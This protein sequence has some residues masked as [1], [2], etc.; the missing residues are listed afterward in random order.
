VVSSIQESNPLTDWTAH[1]SLSPSHV[2][3]LAFST[4]SEQFPCL[5]QLTLLCFCFFQV[6]A[7]ARRAPRNR[8]HQVATPLATA[9][10][11]PHGHIARL[12]AARATSLP[13]SQPHTPRPRM[14]RNCTAT[15]LSTSQPHMSPHA[16]QLHG[17]RRCLPRSRT[18]RVPAHLAACITSPSPSQP[19]TPRPC[20]PR[21]CTGHV[22]ARLAAAHTTSPPPSQPHTQRHRAPRCCTGHVGAFLAADAASP[23]T[24]LL[25]GP[26]RRLPRSRCN[27]AAH[28][29]AA[30]ATSAPSPQPTQRRRAPRCCTGHVGAFP[31]A[32]AA[33]PCASQLHGPRRSTPR[34]CPHYVVTP[35]AAA[36]AGL[37]C[38]S[39][40]H[41][42]R[43]RFP[44]SRRSVAVHCCCTGHVSAFLAADAALPRTTLLPP[45]QCWHLGLWLWSVAVE[46]LYLF[47]IA[48]I[49]LLN[50][51]DCK[52]DKYFRMNYK[53]SG[54]FF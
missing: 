15:S 49:Y 11:Q 14:P 8:T 19:H 35:I 38:A 41:G 48:E 2:W 5:Y 7:P 26:R 1:G 37:P 9:P 36:H 51:M 54:K 30:R 23:C 31:A 32:D 52:H 16:L 10:S 42:P 33:S 44:R 34:S 45:L 39:L 12:A 20:A 50:L 4:S 21:S 25:P 13:P 47:I 29:S 28:L 24:S 18:R 17:P 6:A 46:L 53:E 27:V 3:Q 40:L 43:R 22:A